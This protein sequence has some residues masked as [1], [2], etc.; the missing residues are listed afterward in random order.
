MAQ[1]WGELVPGARVESVTIGTM[2]AERV[3]P[4]QAKPDRALVWFFG[5]GYR[6]GSPATERSLA[7]RIADP[8]QAHAL[9][10]AYR[11]C[12]EHP[13]DPSLEEALTAYRWL[14]DQVGSADRV[15][16][17]GVSAGG[18]LA[19]PLLCALRDQG[20]ELHK[21]SDETLED[22]ARMANAIVRGWIN[23]YGRFCPSALHPPLRRINEYVIRWAE[24]K[25]KRLLGRTRR[26]KEFLVGVARVEPTLF[27]HW[28]WGL[29]P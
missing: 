8:I 20:D 25:Y 23:Y 17:G 10:P 11:L 6:S 5:G 14:R 21:R 9:L 27:A 12:P 24:R 29:V 28:R 2:G 22:L 3:V 26:A 13:L 7:S 19:L 18:G 4:P 15:I 16:V 1:R